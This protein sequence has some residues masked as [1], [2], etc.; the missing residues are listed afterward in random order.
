MV[1]AEDGTYDIREIAPYRPKDYGDNNTGIVIPQSGNDLGSVAQAWAEQQTHVL[2]NGGD[3]RLL[4]NVN[5]SMNNWIAPSKSDDAK[6]SDS[7][8]RDPANVGPAV[9]STQEPAAPQDRSSSIDIYPTSMRFST[10][11]K[12]EMGFAGDTQLTCDYRGDSIDVDL[13]HP[14]NQSLALKL[15]HSSKDGANTVRLNYSW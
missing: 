1:I 3:E 15:R 7:T 11:T 9:V 5:K 8:H 2:T 6:D 4:A 14:V 13:N 10:L 12:I